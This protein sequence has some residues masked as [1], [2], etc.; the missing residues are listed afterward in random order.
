MHDPEF[1]RKF[2]K[3][4]WGTIALCLGA[5][6]LVISVYTLSGS[7]LSPKPMWTIAGFLPPSDGG[8]VEGIVCD[9]LGNPIAG[10]SVEI[11]DAQVVTDIHG[12]FWVESVPL[13]P[14][15]LVVKAP[16]FRESTVQI[17]V[18]PGM[19]H[20]RIGHDTGLWPMDFYV[21]FH[22][23][24]NSL[25]E[26]DTQLLFGLVEVVNPGK[27]PICIS[28]IEIKDPQGRVVYD[29]LESND[30]LHHI[31]ET[32]NLGLMMAPIPAYILPPQSVVVFE[33]DAL[34]RPTRGSYHL[35]LAYASPEEHTRGRMLAL[36]LADEMVYDPDLDPH[37]P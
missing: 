10:A 15:E 18:E 20:P 29:L 3:V 8:T 27:E 25:E 21:R 5:L 32:Y 19:N 6:Y 35:W 17:L 23:F 9:I 37:T 36:H 31:S 28:K 16:R 24:T 13:G 12:R 22:A 7:F 14:V 26:G 1:W 33:L 34:P 11:L 2:R 30:V 4:G